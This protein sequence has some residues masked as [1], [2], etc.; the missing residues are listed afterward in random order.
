MKKLNILGLGAILCV[1]AFG[2]GCTKE[3]ID[4][5]KKV[6]VNTC[7]STTVKYSAQIK[8]LLDAQCN[9]C[10][11]GTAAAGAGII[12][13]TYA[14]AKDAALNGTLASS[15]KRPGTNVMPKGGTR[16]STCLVAQIDKWVSSGAPNN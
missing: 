15:V 6:V 9:V 8:P 14:A 2:T 16:L 13:D 4:D 5:P 12:L 11:G 1:I 3:Y 7:D 10:H